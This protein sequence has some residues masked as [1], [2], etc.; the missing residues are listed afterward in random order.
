MTW[1]VTYKR[2]LFMADLD[3]FGKPFNIITCSRCK[4]QFSKTGYMRHKRGCN[5]EYKYKRTVI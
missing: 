4:S 1:K 5:P 2:V 3:E